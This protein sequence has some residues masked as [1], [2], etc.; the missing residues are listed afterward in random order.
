MPSWEFLAILAI[1][2]VLAGIVL[3]VRKAVKSGE[4]IRISI[5]GRH[6]ITIRRTGGFTTRNTASLT[7]F[8]A[9]E[10]PDSSRKKAHE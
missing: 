4:D 5:C 2:A 7:S 10:K 8:S 6:I 3:L 1:G 9:V